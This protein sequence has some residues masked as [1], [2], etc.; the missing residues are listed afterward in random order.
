MVLFEVTRIKRNKS[1]GKR[2]GIIEA[3]SKKEA[4]KFGFSKGIKNVRVFPVKLIKSKNKKKS[5]TIFSKG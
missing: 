4:A 2:I 1:T 3:K 5:I